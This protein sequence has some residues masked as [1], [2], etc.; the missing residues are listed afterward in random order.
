M[1]KVLIACLIILFLL[2][3][4]LLLPLGIDA[5]YHAGQT[6]VKGKLGPVSLPVFTYPR[7]ADA[8]PRKKKKKEKRP[9]PGKPGAETAE[10]AEEKP[11]WERWKALLDMGLR[12]LGRFRRKLTVEFFQLHMLISEPDP[13]RTAL[14]YGA[15]SAAVGT[16]LPALEQAV[17]FRDKDVQLR[18]DF[19]G[20]GTLLHIRLVLTLR[21]GQI[22]AIAAAFLWE[23]LSWKRRQ[24][25]AQAPAGEERNEV[26]GKQDRRS[27][28]GDHGQAQGHG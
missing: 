20:G 27:A 18:A 4:L 6:R 16:V 21:V 23:Y 12:A 24:T 2:A 13:C 10:E 9:K 14:A 11:D 1:G 8:P 5:E 25:K 17:H 19:G 7:D 15:A 22:L 3:A 26:H 28:S